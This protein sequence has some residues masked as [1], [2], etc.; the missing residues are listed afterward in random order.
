M[1]DTAVAEAHL[2]LPSRG[3]TGTSV[4][5]T[6]K[7]AAAKVCHPTEALASQAYSCLAVATEMPALIGGG[8]V[9]DPKLSWLHLCRAC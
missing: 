8:T 1:H 3:W 7:V 2:G 6:G 4:L 5:I 9:N